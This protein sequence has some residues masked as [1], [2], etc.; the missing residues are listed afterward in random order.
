MNQIAHRLN[1][2]GDPHPGDTAVLA[3]AGGSWPWSSRRLPPSTPS[4]M[5]PPQTVGRPD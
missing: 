4:P 2:G 5:R 3:E 1:A